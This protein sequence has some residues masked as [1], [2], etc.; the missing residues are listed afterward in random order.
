ML[1]L[2]AHRD[3]STALKA[4]HSLLGSACKEHEGNKT[5]FTKVLRVIIGVGALGHPVIH[6]LLFPLFV[7]PSIP[8]NKHASYLSFT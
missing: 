8:I 6:L 2:Q 3:E 1:L 7:P 5:I 4:Q